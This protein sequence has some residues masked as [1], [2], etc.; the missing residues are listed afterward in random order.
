MLRQRQTQMNM[1]QLVT[2]SYMGQNWVKVVPFKTSLIPH[3]FSDSPVVGKLSLN[4]QCIHGI[5][6]E[7]IA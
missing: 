4:L 6:F 2:Y 3:W 1:T 5:G 7:G